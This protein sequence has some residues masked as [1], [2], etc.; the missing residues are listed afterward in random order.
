MRRRCRLCDNKLGI[1]N[2]TSR[3]AAT[4][5]LCISCIRKPIEEEQCIGTTTKKERCK[6]RKHRKSQY[7]K[8]HKHM[9]A[10]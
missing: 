7:C 2:H 3:A 8:A 6:L 5:G 10:I 4:T 9:E 1:R